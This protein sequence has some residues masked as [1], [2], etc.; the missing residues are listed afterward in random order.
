[1]ADTLESLEIQVK[2]SATGAADEINKVA[3]SVKVLGQ[4]LTSVVPKLK[5]FSSALSGNSFTIND[6]ST[7]QYADTINNVKQAASGAKKATTEASKGISEMAKSASKADKPLGNFIASLKRIAFYRIIRGIIKSITQAISEGLQMAYFFSQGAGEDANRFAAAMDKMKAST[8]VMKGQLGS[9]F[10]SLLAAIQPIL[11]T[12]IDLVTRAADAIAQFFA[13]FTGKTYLKATE[14]SAKFA[15]NMKAGGAAAKEWKNQLMG[16]DEINRLNEPS[17]GGGGGGSNPMDGFDFEATPINEKLLDFI[18][19]IKEKVQP[20]IERLK[21]SFERLKEAWVRFTENF[22][23]SVLKDLATDL[24][25]LPINAIAGALVVVFD[26]LTLILDI[27][28]AINTGDWSKVW[29]DFKQLLYDLIVLVM[30]LFVGL[31][32]LAM[33]ALILVVS[34]IDAVIGTHFADDLRA[35]KKAFNEMYN[36][37]K[38][39]E[40]GLWGLKRVLGL[41]Q[42]S[43]E[44]AATATEDLSSALVEAGIDTEDFENKTYGVRT[45]VDW[46]L[47]G[48]RDFGAE[49]GAIITSLFQPLA[50]LCA[51]IDSVLQGFGLMKGINARVDAATANGSIY[52]QGFASGGFPNEGQLFVANEG[53][54]PEM[55][56]TIGGRTAVATNDDIVEAVRQGVYDA[57][58]AANNNGGNSTSFKLYL[59]SREIK[60]GLK[61]VDRA[62][63]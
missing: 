29:F 9:A 58:L 3:A 17:S 21:E 44:S 54:A 51:W 49:V 62:W 34:A 13:A 45:A 38:Q 20:N 32:N 6:Q 42:E 40:D 26:T 56:G 4:Y 11:L 25:A 53:N 59:D 41:T 18:N 15:D 27:L 36:A 16:F 37:S 61:Q 33:D 30:D 1:M 2:H 8:N 35:D 57:V 5:E 10:I 46:V 24:I 23:D 19:T 50:D 55:V 39:S 31:T 12:L 48:F 7:N 60:Y 43:T 14:T 52:L 63:G 22:D 47:N 28:N